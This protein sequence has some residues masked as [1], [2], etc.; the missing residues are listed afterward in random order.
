MLS[1]HATS[2]TMPITLGASVDAS[3]PPP[4]LL[5]LVPCGLLELEHAAIPPAAPLAVRAARHKAKVVVL[6]TLDSFL[7]PRF[8]EV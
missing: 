5:L 3:L 7:P 8:I 1:V 4:E 6:V 2:G